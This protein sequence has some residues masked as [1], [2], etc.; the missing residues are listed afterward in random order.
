VA[1]LSLI[2]LLAQFLPTEMI[3]PHF[4]I[5]VNKVLHGF[6]HQN[7]VKVNIENKSSNHNNEILK[8]KI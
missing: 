7:N 2:A 5:T 6:L 3:I 1:I 8:K 4:V